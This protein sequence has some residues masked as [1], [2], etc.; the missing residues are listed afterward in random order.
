MHSKDAMR[1][2]VGT[3]RTSPRIFPPGDFI[4]KPH[5]LLEKIQKRV[6]K[7]SS[8]DILPKANHSGLSPT[9]LFPARIP[10][11]F[12]KNKDIH[13]ALDGLRARSVY[14]GFLTFRANF[15]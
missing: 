1:A 2:L 3:Y 13:P 15:R 11:G 4:T 5:G 7:I 10:R 8:L 6:V 9:I 12:F 14:N